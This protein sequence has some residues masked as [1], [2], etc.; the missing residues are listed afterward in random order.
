MC[1]HVM[2]QHYGVFGELFE[3]DAP[4]RVGPLAHTPVPPI[5]LKTGSRLSRHLYGGK[6]I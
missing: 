2:D 4:K 3:G 6:A 5:I 1:E